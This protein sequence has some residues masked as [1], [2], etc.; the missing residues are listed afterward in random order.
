MK[1]SILVYLAILISVLIQHV[2]EAARC[3][4]SGFR[5]D[6]D[7]IEGRTIDDSAIKESSLQ[8]LKKPAA[9]SCR[10]SE[11]VLARLLP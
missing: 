7:S 6:Y 11:P 1:R 4:I 3:L 5:V 10:T 8:A 2:K 9:A